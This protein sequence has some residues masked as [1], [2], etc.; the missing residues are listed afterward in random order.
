MDRVAVYTAIY[1]PYDRVKPAPAGVRSVL[2]TDLRSTAAAAHELG[3]EPRVVRHGIATLHGAPAVTAPMLAHKWWKT[4]PQLA[5]PDVD[6]SIWL[7]GSMETVVPDLADRCLQALGGD[8]WVMVRHPWRDCAIE[9][10][11]YSATLTWR[12]DHDAL[13]RQTDFYARFHP[14]HWGLF[15]TGAN[16]RRHGD[17]VALL[18]DQWWRE[19]VHWSHQDQV[20][21]PVLLRLAQLDMLPG[22]GRP[23]QW[24][25]NM[26]WDEWWKLHEHG[27]A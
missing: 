22:L 4:H 7:D 5:L 25:T 8:D 17:E 26:P 2:Y 11:Y 18:C 13:T 14:R 21:L 19:C 1:G 6:V 23:V 15:A 12:Y 27:R 9:E 16:V 10:G 24:N 20:S 3:W